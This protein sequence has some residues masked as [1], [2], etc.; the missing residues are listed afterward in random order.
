M[1]RTGQHKSPP[2]ARRDSAGTL[3]CPVPTSTPSI[4][5]FPSSRGQS[6]NL[7]VCS[8]TPPTAIGQLCLHTSLCAFQPCRGAHRIVQ[9]SPL[10]HVSCQPPPR[11][12]CSTMSSLLP[13]VPRVPHMLVLTLLRCTVCTLAMCDPV[14]PAHLQCLTFAPVLIIKLL[15]LAHPLGASRE[16]LTAHSQARC[17]LGIVLLLVV[18]VCTAVVCRQ[19]VLVCSWCEPVTAAHTAIHQFLAR[20]CC[21]IQPTKPPRTATCGPVA[22]CSMLL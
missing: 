21:T 17:K 6:H 14:P 20:S 5:S 16:C 15:V 12:S 3:L 9:Q 13:R 10:A 4:C 1:C 11:N 22:A 8:T 19:V 2:C 7:P 18:P